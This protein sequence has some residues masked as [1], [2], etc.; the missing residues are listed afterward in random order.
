MGYLQMKVQVVML[1]DE[2]R[3]TFRKIKRFETQMYFFCHFHKP[4]GYVLSTM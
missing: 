1:G 3:E 2:F 4:Y